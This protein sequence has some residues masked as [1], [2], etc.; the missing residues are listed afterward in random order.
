[1]YIGVCL[2]VHVPVFQ[3]SDY[4]PHRHLSHGHCRTGSNAVSHL[5]GVECRFL[6]WVES[7]SRN[8][9]CGG[10]FNP[11]TTGLEVS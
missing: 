11:V 1:M 3:M 8:P 4:E 5:R 10:G 2:H 7:G 9:S 6:N